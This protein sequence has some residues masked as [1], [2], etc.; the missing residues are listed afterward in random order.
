MHCKKLFGTAMVGSKGQIVIP[1]SAREELK[2]NTSDR[3]Y[4]IGTPHKGVVMLA[5]EEVLEDFVEQINLQV[6][7]YKALKAKNR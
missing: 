7:T 3:L 2:I 6:E 1:A 4:V 5:K